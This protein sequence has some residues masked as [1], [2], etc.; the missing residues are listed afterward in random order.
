MHLN[1]LYRTEGMPE[2]AGVLA[3]AD[4]TY[5]EDG[6]RRVARPEREERRRPVV[7]ARTLTVENRIVTAAR[8]GQE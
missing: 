3:R 8:S 4:A 5:V 1:S 2:V 6:A 7:A